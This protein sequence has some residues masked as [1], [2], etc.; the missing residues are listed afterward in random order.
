M[1]EQDRLRR[2]LDAWE[3]PLPGPALERRLMDSYHREMRRPGW[4][5]RFWTTRISVPVPLA[6]GAG[7]LVLLAFVLL[8]TGPQPQPRPALIRAE[9]SAT[10][11]TVGDFTGFRPVKEWRVQV[12]RKGVKQ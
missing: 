7:L 2:A 6:A 12:E 10:I 4:W 8:R 9:Q 1:D 11:I 5:R 3:A